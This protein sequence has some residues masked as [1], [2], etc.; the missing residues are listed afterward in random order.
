MCNSDDEGQ[1]TY[2]K[3][4][5]DYKGTHCDVQKTCIN[6]GPCQNGAVCEE[7]EE[8]GEYFC[9]NCPIAFGGPNCVND[10]CNDTKTIP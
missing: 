7:L 2:C 1:F 10:E 5:D 3:C 6:N 4:G 8:E 9:T